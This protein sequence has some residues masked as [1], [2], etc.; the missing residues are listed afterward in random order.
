MIQM[1]GKLQIIIYDVITYIAIEVC[2]RIRA[3]VAQ[4]GAANSER[5]SRDLQLGDAMEDGAVD[6]RIATWK[7][8]E[9]RNG[10]QPMAS[11]GA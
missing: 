7:M 8:D 3:I 2:M 4:E 6:G 10:G 5:P 9:G 1:C 11:G